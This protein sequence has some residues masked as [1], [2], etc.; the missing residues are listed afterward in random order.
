MQVL[1]VAQPTGQVEL[2]GE[3]VPTAVPLHSVNWSR[4]VALVIDMGEKRTGGY[5]VKVTGVELTD[6]DQVTLRLQVTKP[7]PGAFVTQVFTHPYTVCH[8]PRVG[9]RTGPVTV[10]AVDQ[11][12]A[13]VVRQVVQL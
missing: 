13:E 8:L 2:P 12:G 7:G 4:E 3:L 9:L 6:A 5:S 1:L 10:T 11:T